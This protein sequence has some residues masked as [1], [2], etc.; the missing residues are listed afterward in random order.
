MGCSLIN[1]L[2]HIHLR[3]I[4][5][6]DHG[7][8]SVGDRN[9]AASE[10]DILETCIDLK[11][12]AE[13]LLN[14]FNKL[15]K[16]SGPI[17]VSVECYKLEKNKE[18]IQTPTLPKDDSQSKALDKPR[19]YGLPSRP[20]PKDLNKLNRA[21]PQKGQSETGKPQ[22]VPLAKEHQQILGRSAKIDW[23][24]IDY[25]NHYRVDDNHYCYPS[26]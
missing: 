16:Q 22:S 25:N 13:Q 6:S 15:V 24:N 2:K 26:S 9:D 1:N 5:K 19:A 18:P 12:T 21:V 11:A 8:E 3:R 7:N 20:T 4:L 17:G 10:E 14:H 23:Y